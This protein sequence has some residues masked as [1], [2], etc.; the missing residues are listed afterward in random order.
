[1]TV[2]DIPKTSSGPSTSIAPMCGINQY[3]RR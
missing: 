3:R 1:M 2:F